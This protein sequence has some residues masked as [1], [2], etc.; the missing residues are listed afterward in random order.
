[1]V[2]SGNCG[3]CSIFFFFFLCWF[4][5]HSLYICVCAFVLFGAFCLPS[6]CVWLKSLWVD[7]WSPPSLL[8]LGFQAESNCCTQSTRWQG[9][10]R[11]LPTSFAFC[12][13]CVF[14][15]RPCIP[16]HVYFCLFPSLLFFVPQRSPSPSSRCGHTRTIPPSSCLH[17]CVRVCFV[18][19]C[20]SA[21]SKGTFNLLVVVVAAAR[22]LL[23]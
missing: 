23:S 9:F 17:V 20:L 2:R 8:L 12:H 4:R 19:N 1:M 18:L 22:T 14:F 16:R 21:S 3:L 11:L 7:V 6:V 15:F 10:F 5:F 13:V